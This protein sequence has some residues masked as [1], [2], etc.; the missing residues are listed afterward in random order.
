MLFWSFKKEG[1]DRMD[2]EDNSERVV[3]VSFSLRPARLFKGH[4]DRSHLNMRCAIGAT[5][6]TQAYANVQAVQF[7]LDLKTAGRRRAIALLGFGFAAF[8]N[9]YRF[10][11]SFDA[12]GCQI[13]SR[14]KR[15]DH[16]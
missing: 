7:V 13:S 6:S 12:T 14:E 10:F 9:M 11:V 15:K 4:C 1:V 5:L 8:S 3:F 16:R 2:W